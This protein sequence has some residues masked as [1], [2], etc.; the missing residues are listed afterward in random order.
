MV[1]QA[2][3]EGKVFSILFWMA[4]NLGRSDWDYLWVPTIGV[5]VGVAVL[6]ADGARLNALL[7]GDETAASL[8]VN[9]HRL[10]YR[11]LAVTALLTALMVALSGMIGFVGLVVPHVARLTVGSDHRR[12]VPVAAL[13]GATFLVLCDLASR[14]VLAPTDIPVG[15][16]TGFVGAPF[17]LWLLH[18]TES[19]GAV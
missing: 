18:R 1:L 10:R 16:V 11:L 7:I 17:F 19:L 12:V 2:Q 5:V 3:D 15:I 4:G 14:A 6:L 13:G 9:T 8:G